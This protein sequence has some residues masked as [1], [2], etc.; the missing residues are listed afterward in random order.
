MV[1]ILDLF[2][3]ID[4]I[5]LS[6]FKICVIDSPRYD[7]CLCISRWKNQAVQM[8]ELQPQKLQRYSLPVLFIQFETPI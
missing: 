5:T 3:S 8:F 6:F 1:V 2:T 4:A 7:H